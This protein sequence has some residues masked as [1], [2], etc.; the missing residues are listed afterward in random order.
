M[1]KDVLDFAHKEQH[2]R[3][4]M[5]LFVIGSFATGIGSGAYHM[6]YTFAFQGKAT[7]QAFDSVELF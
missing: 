3:K 4:L 1:L 5:L 2:V 7:V 6:S